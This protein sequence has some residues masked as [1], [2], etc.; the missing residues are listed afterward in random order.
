[1]TISS[2]SVEALRG[3][4]YTSQESEFLY[5]VAI[6]SGYFTHRQFLSFTRTKPGNVSYKFIS[7]LVRDRLAS[8]HPYRAGGRVYHLFSRKVYRAIERDN[9]SARKRHQLDYIKSRLVALDFVLAHPHHHY[10]ETDAEK[11]SF[12]GKEMGVRVELLPARLYCSTKSR[13]ATPHYFVDRFPLYIN[14]LLSPP[15]VTF[16]YVDPGSVTLQPF[17]TH[18]STYSELLRSLG[19]FDF[20]YVGP[21]SRLF[22]AAESEFYRFLAGRSVGMSLTDLIRYY[23]VR[24][25]WESNHRVPSSDV[26]FL[27]EAKARYIGKKFDSLYEKWRCGGLEDSSVGRSLEEFL[28]APVGVFEA[29][30]FGSSLSVFSK[31]IETSPESCSGIVCG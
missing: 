27:K 11:V 17:R 7:K 19:R 4:G 22:L 10:L 21:S 8:F 30:I 9:L 26:L 6:H 23:Q 3:L 20:F 16:T 28:V 29:R 13:K 1:M 14:A 24:L 12:F 31:A 15:V 5:L 18:L 25:A 2:H